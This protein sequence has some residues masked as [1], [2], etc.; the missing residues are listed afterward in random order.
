[1][2]GQNPNMQPNYGG[3]YGAPQY[4]N[5][6][7]NAGPMYGNNYQGGYAQNPSRLM[8]PLAYVGYALLYFGIPLVGFIFLIVHA[9]D[10]TYLNRRNFA[11]SYFVMIL[12]LIYNING[13]F[14][15]GVIFWLV[16]TCAVY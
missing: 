2:D 4:N 8:K 13:I 10:D 3:N 16:S 11:R 7:Y 5:G 14:F 6:G 15:I 9:L 1:M 12:K